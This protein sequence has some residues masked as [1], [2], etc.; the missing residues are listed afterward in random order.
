[1]L[2]VYKKAEAQDVDRRQQGHMMDDL[3]KS[4]RGKKQAF[5]LMKLKAESPGPVSGAKKDPFSREQQAIVEV[6]D[7]KSRGLISS[8]KAQEIIDQALMLDRLKKRMLREVPTKKEEDIVE[9][10]YLLQEQ[11]KQQSDLHPSE[12]RT[13]KTLKDFY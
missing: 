9:S 3:L 6:I 1:M 12:R 4:M 10:Q 5:R 11:R 7:F 8:E 13:I 2:D